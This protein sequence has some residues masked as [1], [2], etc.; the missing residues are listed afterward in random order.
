M[1]I[2]GDSLVFARQLYLSQ[3]AA[4]YVKINFDAFRRTLLL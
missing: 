2:I 3:V 4:R 1:S